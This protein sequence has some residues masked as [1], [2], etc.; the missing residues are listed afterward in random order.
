MPLINLYPCT[1]QY[2]IESYY[3]Y[4]NLRLN[5]ETDYTH[6]INSIFERTPLQNEINDNIT[7]FNHHSKFSASSSSYEHNSNSNSLSTTNILNV[8]ARPFYPHPV[9][10]SAKCEKVVYILNANAASFVPNYSNSTP[11]MLNPVV[12]EFVP[13]KKINIENTPFSGLGF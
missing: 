10:M 5:E 8:Y 11:F 3:N 6:K 9:I 13:G 1:Y 2:Y 4:D 7:I 12:N